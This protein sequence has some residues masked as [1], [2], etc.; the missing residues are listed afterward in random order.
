MKFSVAT[1][2]AFTLIPSQSPAAGEVAPPSPLV[3][4]PPASSLIDV[5]Y[6][7]EEDP[8][9]SATKLPETLIFE[10]ALANFTTVAAGIV[11]VVPAF[12]V[13]VPSMTYVL[14]AVH[15][16]FVAIFPDTVESQGSKSMY[17]GSTASPC[18]PGLVLVLYGPF[19]VAPVVVAGQYTCSAFTRAVPLL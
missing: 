12:T 17:V 5:K 8:A 19:I 14:E 1:P 16:V 18:P 7:R 13:S 6:I 9:E 15:V 3:S 2:P 11:S 4:P 10:V